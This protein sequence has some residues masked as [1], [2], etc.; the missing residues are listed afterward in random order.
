[1][2]PFPLGVL[3]AAAMAPLL[4]QGGYTDSRGE[5]WPELPQV[6]DFASVAA[7]DARVGHEVFRTPAG[8]AFQLDRAWTPE[9]ERHFRMLSGFVA[10]GSQGGS[11]HGLRATVTTHHPVDEEYRAVFPSR[12]AL[13]QHVRKVV[14]RADDALEA[15]WG[16]N[17]VPSTGYAWDSEDGDDIVELLGEAFL[18]GGGLAQQDMM[19]AFSAD[20]GSGAEIGIAILGL[21]VALV[22]RYGTVTTEATICQHEIGHCYTLVHCCDSHCVMQAVLDPAAFGSFHAYQ[23]SCSGQNHADVLQQQQNRY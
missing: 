8:H 7:Y 4:S 6:E 16:I 20:Q 2:N 14:E 3:A 5:L 22:K 11:G 19:I 13:R 21:P 12:Y 23:E 15:G 18:E 9:E 10:Q 17:L 1:M